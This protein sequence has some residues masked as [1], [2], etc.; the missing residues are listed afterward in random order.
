V[1]RI[2]PDAGTLAR[3]VADLVA[4]RSA[5]AIRARGRFTLALAGGETPRLTYTLLADGT[6]TGAMDW[7]RV[8]LLWGDERCVSPDDPRSNYRM[9]RLALLTRVPIPPQQV[10]RIRGEDEPHAAAAAYETLLRGL[11]GSAG[12]E[13]PPERGPDLVLLGMGQDGHT[14]SLFPGQ[15]AVRERVRWVLAEQ[16]GADAMWRV[17]LTP[18]VLNAAREVVFLVAGARKAGV[19]REVLEGPFAP[20]RLPAQAVRP[21]RGHLTWLVDSTAAAALR[22][23]PPAAS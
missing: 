9:A 13:G 18:V 4:A 21:T 3:A 17:T 14:A 6:Y 15:E 10:H 20:D 11:L 1:I 2:L 16:G 22:R 19:L 7:T 23:P 12:A 5:D 8:H